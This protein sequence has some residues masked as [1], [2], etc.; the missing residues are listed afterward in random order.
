LVLVS[1]VACLTG[2][3]FACIVA[4]SEF[5]SAELTAHLKKPP[6]RVGNGCSDNA[7]RQGAVVSDSTGC[8]SISYILSLFTFP[9]SHVINDKCGADKLNVSTDLHRSLGSA[10][11]IMSGR[12]AGQLKE[13]VFDS[14]R[15]KRFFSFPQRPDRLWGPL[16]LL[17]SE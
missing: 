6:P 5:N 2:H 9:D 12:R 4:S 3:T 14:F 13:S 11:D 15:V 7:L 1:G 17:F 16:S 8:S 10:I